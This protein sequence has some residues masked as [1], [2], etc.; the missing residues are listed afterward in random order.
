MH[1]GLIRKPGV[2]HYYEVSSKTSR[3]DPARLRLHDPD[4]VIEV[5]NLDTGKV[6]IYL[7]GQA[8]P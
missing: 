5:L 1:S 7:P 4:A 2:R 3:A 6:D 8:I